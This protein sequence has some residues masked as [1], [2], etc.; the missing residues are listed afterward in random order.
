MYGKWE[1]DVVNGPELAQFEALEPHE[2]A[3]IYRRRANLTQG[4]VAKDLQC[5]RYWLNLMETGRAPV[6]DLIQYWEQ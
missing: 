2:R 3:L 1:R 4:A 6:D 5:C